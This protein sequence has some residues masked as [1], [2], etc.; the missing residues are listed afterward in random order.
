MGIRGHGEPDLIGALTLIAQ[1]CLALVIAAH[2]A[3]A[4]HAA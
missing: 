1:V 3:W 4:V 2:L